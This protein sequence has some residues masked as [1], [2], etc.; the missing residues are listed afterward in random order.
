MKSRDIIKLLEA[1][2]WYKAGQTGSNIHFKHPSKPGKTTVPHP[3]KDM[4]L[5][6]LISIEKQSGV[7][8]KRR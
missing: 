8:L 7:R 3:K 4:A 2:G 1:D 5:G 6:T